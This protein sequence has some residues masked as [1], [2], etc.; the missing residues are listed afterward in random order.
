MPDDVLVIGYGSDLRGDDA[1]GV[2][3]AEAVAAAGLPGVRVMTAPQL[4]PEITTDLAGSRAVI[5]VDA[6]AVDTVVEV[7]RLAPASPSWRLTHHV[8][9]ASLLALAAALG[10]PPADAYVV[11]IPARGFQLG[12]ELS[13]TTAAALS[14]AVDRIVDLCHELGR[15]SPSMP[16]PPALQPGGRREPGTASS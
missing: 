13:G 5:F 11:S 8:A 6:S 16:A 3:A 10:S 2:R 4:L 14:E 9:P 15:V 1:A 7:R 12:A